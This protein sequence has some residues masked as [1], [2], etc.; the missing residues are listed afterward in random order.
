MEI[1]KKRNLNCVFGDARYLPFPDNYFNTVLIVNNTLGN[2]RLGKIRVLREANRVLIPGGKGFVSVYEDSPYTLKQRI[3]SYMSLNHSPQVE[4]PVVKAEG[5][6]SEAFSEE[7]LKNI[8][9]HAGIKNYKIICVGKIG[10]G[11][12]WEK[13]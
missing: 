8:L 7:R 11:A 1:A 3:L 9:T 12:I 5:L 2:I 13:T 10:I 4:G 6:Y